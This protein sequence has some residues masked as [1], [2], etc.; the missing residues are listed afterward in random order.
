MGG[1]VTFV[2]VSESKLALKSQCHVCKQYA[3]SLKLETYF[4]SLKI[5]GRP[6]PPNVTVSAYVEGIVATKLYA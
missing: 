2:P 1:Y 3:T 5:L 6:H 4:Q